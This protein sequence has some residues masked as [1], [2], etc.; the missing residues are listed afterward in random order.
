MAVCSHAMRALTQ[1]S[2]TASESSLTDPLRLVVEFMHIRAIRAASCQIEPTPIASVPSSP[3]RLFAGVATMRS[4]PIR[5]REARLCANRIVACRM[6]WDALGVLASA[7]GIGPGACPQPIGPRRSCAVHRRDDHARRWDEAGV[8][9][10]RDRDR[11]GVPPPGLPRPARPDP[12][13]PGGARRFLGSK[14]TGKRSKLVE[15]LLNHPDFAKN[16]ATQW[17]VLL[18]GRKAAGAR[19]RPRRPRRL[20]PPAVPRR[21]ALERDRLRPGHGQGARTRRTARSTSRWP[22]WRSAPS[23]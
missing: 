23:R 15:Y 18:I 5:C 6:S 16:F 3:W 14:E 20:A 2:V 11:R 17:T 21:P 10:S 19:G 22:T 13:H 8:K 9:P 1:S 12:E 4:S 7:A